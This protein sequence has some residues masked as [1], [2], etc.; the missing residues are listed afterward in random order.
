MK[1]NMFSPVLGKLRVQ[2]CDVL[3]TYYDLKI[4]H[5]FYRRVV[6]RKTSE[7]LELR[8][9]IFYRLCVITFFFINKT[10]DF[11]GDQE[12]YGTC[13]LISNF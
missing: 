10:I 5:N 11:L 8:R 2:K 7:F 6:I 9:Q 3:L 1:E 13:A 12:F 4:T